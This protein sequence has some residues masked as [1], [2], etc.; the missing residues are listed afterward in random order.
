MVSKPHLLDGFSTKRI[1]YAGILTCLTTGVLAF[2]FKDYLIY[3][4]TYLEAKS[5]DNLIIFHSVVILLYIGVSL[6]IFWGYIL[7]LFICAYVYHFYIGFILVVVYTI[8]GVSIA[9]FICRYVFY[10]YAHSSVKN[11]KYVHIF[12]AIVQS[13]EKGNLY[14]WIIFKLN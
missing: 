7:C 1:S 4:L 14:F 3:L 5:K 6:P 9:F 10:D 8:I 2:I 13:K 11:F 12:N